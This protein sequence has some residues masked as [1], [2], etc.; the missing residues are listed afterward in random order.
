M[1]LNF[2]TS[3]I[4][5]YARH[6][7]TLT[8]ISKRA[9]LMLSTHDNQRIFILGCS[10]ANNN[11]FCHRFVIVFS[12]KCNVKDFNIRDYKLLLSKHI[13]AMLETSLN[14][15]NVSCSSF[16]LVWINPTYVCTWSHLDDISTITHILIHRSTVDN[17]KHSHSAMKLLILAVNS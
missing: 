15:T 4:S 9:S 17:W 16:A 14:Y 7:I 3:K 6:S 12:S 10:T 1:A 13:S 5:I 8:G 11:L 2:E